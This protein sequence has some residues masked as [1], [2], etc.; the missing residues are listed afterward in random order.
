MDAILKKE[1][2]KFLNQFTHFNH[3]FKL[4]IFYTTHATI[5]WIL[6]SKPWGF[7]F[8]ARGLCWTR[9]IDR[10]FFKF[11]EDKDR[12]FKTKL[13]LSLILQVNLRLGATSYGARV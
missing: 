5:L 12:R 4:L 2:F 1:V 9:V 11:L 7:G 6:F 13:T 8:K 10:L 3:Q